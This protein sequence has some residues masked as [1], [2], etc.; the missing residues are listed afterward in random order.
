M[1]LR[2]ILEKEDTILLD[3]HFVLWALSASATNCGMVHSAPC[4]L[5]V[6]LLYYNE[7]T[8]STTIKMCEALQKLFSCQIQAK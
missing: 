6:P 4:L 2:I 8:F 5:S 7:L 3:D 1:F